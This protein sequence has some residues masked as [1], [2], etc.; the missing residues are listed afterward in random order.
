MSSYKWFA[1]KNFLQTKFIG[2]FLLFCSL[3]LAGLWHGSTLNFFMFGIIHGFG[4]VMSQIYNDIL[5]MFLGKK[6]LKRYT[7]KL[8]FKILAMLVTFHYV[9]FSFIFFSPNLKQNI[10]IL[11]IIF[12]NSIGRFFI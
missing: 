11:N 7:N 4:I 2:Y 8:N 9:C 6:G 10:K 12:K 1:A 3:F 5:K